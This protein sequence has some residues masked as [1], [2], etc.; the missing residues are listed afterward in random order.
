MDRIRLMQSMFQP[1]FSAKV[2]YDYLL[3]R[4]NISRH[5]AKICFIPFKGSHIS[6]W[7]PQAASS[8][9]VQPLPLLGIWCW[10]VETSNMGMCDMLMGGEMKGWSKILVYWN[11]SGNT[12]SQVRIRFPYVKW[13]KTIKNWIRF[14]ENYGKLKSVWFFFFNPSHVSAETFHFLLISAV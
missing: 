7:H 8:A 13:W 11:G 12:I 6:I 10:Q 2:W 3:L 5:R 14:N 9:A 4:Y 1:T